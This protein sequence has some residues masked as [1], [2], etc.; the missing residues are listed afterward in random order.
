MNMKCKCCGSGENVFMEAF[1]NTGKTAYDLVPICIDCKK[2]QMQNL[3]AESE[4]KNVQEWEEKLK[5]IEW[6]ISHQI[7]HMAFPHIKFKKVAI[8]K[9]AKLM[10]KYPIRKIFEVCTL[11][12]NNK[13]SISEIEKNCK[14]E[15]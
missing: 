13:F 1:I 9:L 6:Q 14:K 4:I 7:I 12:P 11:L 5:K 15:E 10:R 8:K 2:S 3:K